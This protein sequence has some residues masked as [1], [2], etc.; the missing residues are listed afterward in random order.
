MTVTELARATGTPR[1]TCHTVLLALTDGGFV[2]RNQDLRYRLGPACI[3]VGKA[4]SDS[5]TVLREAAIEAERLAHDTSSCVAVLVG[6]NDEMRTIEVFDCAPPLG[7]RFRVGLAVPLVAP[8]GVAFAA[9][10]TETDVQRWLANPGRHLDAG[11]VDRHREALRAVRQRG[12]SITV[13]A[14][15]RSELVEVLNALMVSPHAEDSQR[16]RD[17]LIAGMMLS[18]YLPAALD[19][20]SVLRFSQISAPV[21]DVHGGVAAVISLSGL[22]YDVTGEHVNALGRRIVE[23]TTAATRHTGGTIPASPRAEP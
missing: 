19:D 15:R 9:W 6:E 5:I 21:F 22:T 18:E 23:A 11:E 1:A 2:V 4:A 12:F 8:F 7:L 3:T 10:R 14:N 16:R 20:Q 17:E 13:E